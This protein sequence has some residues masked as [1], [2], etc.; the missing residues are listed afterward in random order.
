VVGPGCISATV[1]AT[2]GP[3]LVGL[4]RSVA[5]GVSK[6]LTT[7]TMKLSRSS[8]TLGSESKERVTVTIAANARGVQVNGTVVVRVSGRTLCVIS[9]HSGRG[10][11]TLASR[12]LRAGTYQVVAVFRGSESLGESTSRTVTLRVDV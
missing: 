3:N 8:V 11:C 4:S 6:A 7:T 2:T 5:F 10:T 1:N 9:V 12:Q